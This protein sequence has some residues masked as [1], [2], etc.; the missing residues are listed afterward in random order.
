M[1]NSGRLGDYAILNPSRKER[2]YRCFDTFEGSLE[3]KNLLA[4][5][6]ELN[7]WNKQGKVNPFDCPPQSPPLQVMLPGPL[8]KRG[9]SM[10]LRDRGIDF[11]L[12]V[13]L[14]TADSQQREEYQRC[15]RTS[16]AENFFA[17]APE[18]LESCEGMIKLRDYLGRSNPL[19]EVIRLNILT[20][21]FNLCLNDSPQLE[22]AIDQVTG[23]SIGRMTCLFY[24]LEIEVKETL[25]MDQ[26]GPIS[27]IFK[28][29]YG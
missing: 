2:I 9:G 8:E 13:K 15:Y 16:S 29:K 12:T 24:E 22:V 21:R 18:E 20:N 17:I 7:S 27:Q 19:L 5:I 1:Q 3:Q 11:V 4:Y 25:A 28:K 23:K 10:S 6:W 14:P 26:L